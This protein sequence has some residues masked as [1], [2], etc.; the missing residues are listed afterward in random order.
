MWFWLLPNVYGRAEV[1]HR[2]YQRMF[3]AQYPKN[4]TAII[5]FVNLSK[6][7]MGIMGTL[8]YVG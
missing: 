7:F 3:K 6:V 5:P 1:T 2:W 4:R 8:E